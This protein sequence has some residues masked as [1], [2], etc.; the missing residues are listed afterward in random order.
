MM[1]KLALQ[2]LNGVGAVDADKTVNTA[3]SIIGLADTIGNLFKKK[4]AK[5]TN[6]SAPKTP[7]QQQ[8][9]YSQLSVF[10]QICIGV[11]IGAAAAGIAYIATK[12]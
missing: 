11:G 3:Q 6:S 5:V 8:P 1:T 7:A 12:K 9:I 2:Y 10:G 4:E